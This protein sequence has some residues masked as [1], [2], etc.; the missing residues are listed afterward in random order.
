[1]NNLEK[2]KYVKDQLTRAL[3]DLLKEKKLTDISVSELTKQA[4]VGRV[5]FYRNYSDINDILIEHSNMLMKKWTKDFEADP[6][7]S[8]F[9]VFG[10]LFTHY[11]DHRDFYEIMYQN[12]ITDPILDAVKNKIDYSDDLDN[13]TAYSK[14]FFA[15]GMYGW[16]LEWM[17]RGMSEDADG[18]NSMLFETAKSYRDVANTM[19]Q[20]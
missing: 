14:A 17:K 2:N 20:Q 11:K 10:S 8:I 3:I 1:M 6:A 19:L 4:G 5:S 9:N 13:R 7:S 18:I 15:Y 12:G 16:I